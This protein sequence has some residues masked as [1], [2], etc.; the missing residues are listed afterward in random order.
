[1][2]DPRELKVGD[3]VWVTMLSIG[4][5]HVTRTRRLEPTEG[6]VERIVDGGITIVD[7]KTGQI[8]H[9]IHSSQYHRGEAQWVSKT[10]DEAVEEYNRV[11]YNEIDLLQSL[12]DYNKNKLLK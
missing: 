7:K 11:I 3:V 12:I 2:I 1:M 9:K 10:R 4:P 6:I 8:L 5:S